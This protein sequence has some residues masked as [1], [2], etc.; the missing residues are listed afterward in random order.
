MNIEIPLLKHDAGGSGEA[1]VLVPGGLT[2]WQSWR[3]HAVWLAKSRRAIRVQLLNVELGL[4]DA[5]LPEDYSVS[6]E[7][8]ALAKTLDHLDIAEADF[9]AWSYGGEIALSYAIHHPDRVR[10]LTLI[11]PPAIWVLRGRGP[12]PALVLEQQAFFRTMS[13][14]DVS[15]AQLIKF[16]HHTDIVPPQVDPRTLPPWP[17]W[18][19]HRQSLRM[20][21][22]P[23]THEDSVALLRAFDKPVLLVK[24]ETTNPNL[25]HDVVDVLQEELPNA[26]TVTFP[27]GHA[28]PVVSME[29]F[30]ERFAEFL[31]HLS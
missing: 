21:D 8:T 20:R 25:H 4:N 15:E 12:L 24:G 23:F 2:G 3:Q 31:S 6:Y 27:G 14:E 11:E 18:H 7:V 19:K 30:L 26:Q 5:P 29:P 9:A 17:G 22:T 1:V 10:S 13:R 28:V 16:L